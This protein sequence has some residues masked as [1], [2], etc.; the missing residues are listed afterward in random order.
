MLS[1]NNQNQKVSISNSLVVDTTTTT[2][3]NTKV[4]ISKEIC[5]TGTLNKITPVFIHYQLDSNIIVGEIIYLNTKNKIPIKLLGTIEEDKNYRLLEFDKTGN[6]TGIIFGQPADKVFNGSWFSPRS[7]KELS[8]TLSLADT[9]IQSLD[10]KPIS[11]Q[12]FGSYYYQYGENGNSGDF[13]INNIH[14]NRI[15]FNIISVT[16]KGGNIADVPRDT[17]EIKGNS[18]IYKI[19]ETDSCEFK[20]TFYKDF[21]YINYTKGYC[22]GQFGLNATIDGIFLKT[23]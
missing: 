7:R 12:I 22:S 10:I 5:W 16:G 13:E 6:I 11:N 15:D 8:M 2:L 19:P 21:V 1:C 4:K 3:T 17:I 23:K 9:T 18:F 14:N 20:T